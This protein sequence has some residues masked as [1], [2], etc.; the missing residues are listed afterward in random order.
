[1][2]ETGLF[3]LV[4]SIYR[5]TFPIHSIAFTSYQLIYSTPFSPISSFI[6]CFSLNH[7]LTC[8]R[9]L[10]RSQSHSC[11]ITVALSILL[12]PLIAVAILFQAI[13]PALLFPFYQYRSLTPTVLVLYQ[14]WSNFRSTPLT[15][16]LLL[17]F[18]HSHSITPALSLVL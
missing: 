7:F 1:M 18:C 2:L 14:S 9:S 8:S 11:S 5:F 16:A 13:T 15:H 4:E 3:L 12:Y 6:R 17:S 10:P